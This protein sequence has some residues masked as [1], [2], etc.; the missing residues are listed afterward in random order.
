MRFLR[1]AANLRAPLVL[2]ALLWGCTPSPLAGSRVIA[3]SHSTVTI[4]AGS[5]TNPD[6]DAEAHCAGFGKTAVF[7]GK[8][9][10]SDWKV[11]DIF[12]YD[13]K[14]PTPEGSAPEDPDTE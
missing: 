4:E 14:D 13:C 3:G 12:V 2:L 6:D 7:V 11:T 1:P 10:L 8:Q 9:R 5:W